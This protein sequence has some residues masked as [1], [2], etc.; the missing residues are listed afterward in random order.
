VMVNREMRAL[1]LK[2]EVNDLLARLG[3]PP[4][5]GKAEQP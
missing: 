1:E 2:R 4:R 5:Y 3:Q